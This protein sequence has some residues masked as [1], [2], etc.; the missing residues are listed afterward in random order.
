MMTAEDML[1]EEAAMIWHRER[2]GLPTTIWRCRFRQ[3]A[4]EVF[5]RPLPQPPQ[6]QFRE[7]QQPRPDRKCLAAHDNTF[8]TDPE[9]ID[10]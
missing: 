2:D 4:A 10:E 6:P 3:M 5:G 9:L 8:E 1:I 7:N